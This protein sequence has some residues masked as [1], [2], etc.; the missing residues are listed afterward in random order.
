MSVAMSIIR[1]YKCGQH[2]LI[3]TGRRIRNELSTSSGPG[4]RTRSESLQETTHPSHRRQH[5]LSTEIDQPPDQPRAH[6][7]LACIEH[8]APND[9]GDQPRSS[10]QPENAA[11][12]SKMSSSSAVSVLPA[13]FFSFSFSFCW[14][15]SGSAARARGA[16][17][18]APWYVPASSRHAPTRRW[19]LHTARALCAPGRPQRH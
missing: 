3:Q 12:T 5:A 18:C 10:A 9:D 17:R 14:E 1:S 19:R 6:R 8:S 11:H 13:I 7:T 4:T 15:W 16:S 2:L